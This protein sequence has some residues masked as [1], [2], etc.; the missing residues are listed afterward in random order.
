V[1]AN[2]ISLTA[3][4]M[5]TVSSFQLSFVN[6]IS[7]EYLFR[8]CAHLKSMIYFFNAKGFEFLLYCEY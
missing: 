3:N 8:S 6:L 7:K 2:S 4:D 1:V 5:D